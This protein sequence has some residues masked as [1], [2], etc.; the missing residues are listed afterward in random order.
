M[1]DTMVQCGAC[2]GVGYLMGHDGSGR[3]NVRCPW[4]DGAGVLAVPT[5]DGSDD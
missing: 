5:E 4:C 3:A 2:G 1:V